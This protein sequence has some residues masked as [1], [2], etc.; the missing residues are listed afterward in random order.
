MENG[1]GGGDA[2]QLQF[3]VLV[4]SGSWCLCLGSLFPIQLVE[5]RDK[6]VERTVL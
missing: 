3:P 1:A 5:I 6:W 2:V 4:A